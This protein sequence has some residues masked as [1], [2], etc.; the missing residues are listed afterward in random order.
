M[1]QFNKGFIICLLILLSVMI[2]PLSFVWAKDG[3]SNFTASDSNLTPEK[4]GCCSHHGGV[5]FCGGSGYY[6]C[7]DG[8]R[9]PTCTCSYVPPSPPSQYTLT[10]NKTGTGNG[11]V[12]S[13]PSGINCGVDCSELYD[14]GV[15]ITL[16]ATADA[17]SIFDGW[18]DCNLPAGE[19]CN[20]LMNSNMTV[21]AKFKPI[22][23]VLTLA[24][25]GNG[26]IKVN[27]DIVS[28]PWSGQF[29]A[30]TNV[31]IEAAPDTGWSFVNWHGDLTGN[32]NPATITMNEDKNITANFIEDCN[33]S[34]SIHIIP[35][36]AGSI[37]RESSKVNYCKNDTVTLTANA[38]AGYIFSSWDGADTSTGSVA[39]ILINENKIVSA[40]YNQETFKTFDLSKDFENI[41]RTSR[42]SVT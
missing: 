42:G 28:L 17:N 29:P 9:S 37:A 30:D 15:T 40:L 26:S 35:P 31:T 2:L 38:N 4:S 3:L 6:I 16:T 22:N 27:G 21:T 36:G 18:L 12:I 25:N 8:T 1:H 19:S 7:K 14:K 41:F 32:I 11:Y 39:N 24:K 33:L 23:Y 10:I 13:S 20:V 34:L 5:S